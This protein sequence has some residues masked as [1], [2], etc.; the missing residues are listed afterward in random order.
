MLPS[1]SGAD[2]KRRQMVIH[3]RRKGG[4]TMRFERLTDET[5]L[6]YN[7]AMELYA[8]SFPAHE[9]R[10][11]AS[12]KRI[13]GDE[14]YHFMLLYEEE[15]FV[16]TALYWEQEEFLYL[17]HFCIEPI[18][19]SKGYGAKALALLIQSGK[20]VIL[21]IDPPVDELS[22]RRKGF[23]LRCGFAENPYPH[24]HPP[25]HPD[26]PGHPLVILSAP[27]A[28][29]EGT[30]ERLSRYLQTHVMADVY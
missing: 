14:A 26:T 25:Y 1:G 9:Q 27:D 2:C 8:I 16:G 28:I 11:L 22:C 24:V 18:H 17:E 12:Q 3:W 6:R 19:R 4:E 5:D 15:T 21:E 30:Y 10:R 20:T 29:D 13:L 7:K 23:Y